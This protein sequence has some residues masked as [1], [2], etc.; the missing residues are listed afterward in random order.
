MQRLS[1]PM[2]PMAAVGGAGHR[3]AGARSSPQ[4]GHLPAAKALTR[5]LSASFSHLREEGNVEVL[6]PLTRSVNRTLG[7]S[8]DRSRKKPPTSF[9]YEGEAENGDGT[10]ARLTSP[11]SC[12]SLSSTSSPMLGGSQ[13]RPGLS[14]GSDAAA[15]AIRRR[16]CFCPT[17]KNSSHCVT[18]YAQ[19]YGKHPRLFDFDRRGQ[20]QLN[21]AGIADEMKQQ[22][23]PTV[24]SLKAMPIEA[25]FPLQESTCPASP[26]SNS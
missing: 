9:P 24:E 14:R 21:D 19:V 8:L 13:A 4:G 22:M 12:T 23:S 25:I 10:G 3:G 17:P 5:S 6:T 26:K 20:M 1:S 11:L 16:V 2:L 15:Q 18:P 7:K